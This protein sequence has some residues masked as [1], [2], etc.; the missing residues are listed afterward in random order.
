MNNDTLDQLC[1]LVGIQADY[2]DIW[3]KPH[4]V[5]DASR[6]ALLAAMGIEAGD[7]EQTVRSLL[8]W[9]EQ[10]WAEMLDPVAVVPAGKAACI[11]VRL[12][13]GR[14]KETL[15]WS[16]TLE[17]GPR[18]EGNCAVADLEK[19]DRARAGG[20]E[21]HALGLALP[22]VDEIGYHRLQVLTSA[23][24]PWDITLIVH[25]AAAYWPEALRPPHARTWGLGTQLY[26][27]RS[28]RNWGIGDFSDLVQVVD[29]AAAG[30][31]GLVGINPVHAL[32]P[33]NP[34]HRSPYSPSSRQFLNVLH[35][36]VEDIPEYP[37]CDA[38]RAL[39]SAP[40][41]QA[42]LKA[43]RAA[44]LVA[45]R[46]VAGLKLPV[47]EAIYAHFRQKHLGANS[48]RA[49][50]FRT[51]QQDGGTSLARFALYQALQEDF[52]RHDAS[53]WG[54]PVWPE[55]YRQPDSPEVETFARRHAERVEWFQWL[56]WVADEQ[57]ARV[58]QA[59]ETAGMAVGLYQDLAVGVDR[60]GAETWMHRSLFAD[61]ARVGCPP[62]DFSPLGQDWGLP[63]W[64]PHRLKAAGYA[65]FI[66]MLRANMR[67]AGALRID[68]VMGLMRLYWIPPGLTGAEGG[69]VGYPF[70][71]LLGILAL[72]SQRNR[73]L[74]V[75]EDLG[76]VPDEVRTALA[77]VGVLSYRLFYFERQHDDHFL[78]P[79]W[80]PENALVAGST[81]DLPT[82]AGYWQ[83]RDIEVRCQLGI[84][85]DAVACAARRAE[86]AADRSRLLVALAREGLL[87][88]EMPLDASKLAALSPPLIQA[89]GRYLARTPARLFLV[90]AE[91]MLAELDQA[92]LPGTVDEYPNWRRK[93]ALP[94]EAWPQDP[95]C[96]A[97]T[98]VLA[99]ER[100]ARP[101]R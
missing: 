70:R 42:A 28:A 62:D 73:C 101:L 15:H 21:H 37:E 30:G 71:D 78:P 18:I 38:A 68:H 86:R 92:N 69:Y 25:P 63:P 99:T 66:T 22:P 91:D 7:E 74:V 95:N 14:L 17:S 88:R 53:L 51:F 45:Y 61:E 39:V 4:R 10:H 26:G 12:P 49:K 81:H 23:G 16:I 75:G 97:L 98:K 89:L 47:L 100:P 52:F 83:E 57:M 9:R 64:I 65:P 96:V 33:H 50:A 44:P 2:R 36:G 94:I 40:D 29:W 43:A 48:A 85:A 8:R 11:E 27:L 20:V 55:P 72:E 41:F 87:P 31:A 3:G 46:E 76:T 6:R 82:L 58:S 59:A 79:N 54:W 32:F 5:S 90:Q 1:G 34:D 13:S 56:Q 77:E 67:H 35:I 84:F 93:L 60:A 24:T 19:R 80:Y